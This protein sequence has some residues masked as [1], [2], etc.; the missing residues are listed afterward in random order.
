[1]SVFVITLLSLLLLLWL[2]CSG[3]VDEITEFQLLSRLFCPGLPWFR[4][5]LKMSPTVIPTG[6]ILEEIF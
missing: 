3:C 2:K 1:M 6:N 5:V 4:W